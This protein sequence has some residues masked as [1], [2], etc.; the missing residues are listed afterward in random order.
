MNEFFDTELWLK[1]LLALACGAAIGM[2]RQIREK[3]AGARTN[4]LICVGSTLITMVSIHVALTYAERGINLA[5]PGR[6]AAQIVSGV[7]FIGAG[8]IIQARGAV[9]G[10]TTAATIWVMAGIGLAIGSGFYAPAVATTI[11]ILLIL[12]ALRWLARNVVRPRK[13]VLFRVSASRETGVLAAIQ[14]AVA[15]TELDFGGV[16]LERAGER[17]VVEFGAP[18][19]PAVRDQLLER[20]LAIDSV[21]DIQAQA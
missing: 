8:T 5:D 15:A 13:F 18:C 7:G 20:L 4:M 9:H 6:I 19:T 17:M 3:P 14:D 11:L 10:L 21:E 12:W 16:R 1:L 2:E